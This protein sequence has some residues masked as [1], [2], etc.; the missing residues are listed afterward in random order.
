VG[1]VH[2]TSLLHSGLVMVTT[3]RFRYY[4]DAYA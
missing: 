2:T 3:V 4:R 1:Q